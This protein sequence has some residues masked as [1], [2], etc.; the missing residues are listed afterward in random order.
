MENKASHSNLSAIQSAMKLGMWVSGA[1]FAVFGLLTMQYAWAIVQGVHPWLHNLFITLLDYPQVGEPGLTTFEQNF[2]QYR[3]VMASMSSHALLGGVVVLLGMLQFVPYLRRVKPRVHRTL[4]KVLA[5]CMTIICLSALHF[6]AVT[7]PSEILAGQSFYFI[8]L[9]LAGLALG[10]ISQ[11]VLAVKSGDYRSHM[12]WMGLAFCAFLTAPLLRFNYL[13]VGALDPQVL[14]R[15]VINS[16]P[17]VLT[18]AFV[19]WMLWL[20]WVGD[21]DLPR[22]AKGVNLLTLPAVWAK[23][24]AWASAG[25]LLA[26]GLLATLGAFEAHLEVGK[27][28]FLALMAAFV[29]SRVI[30]TVLSPQTWQAG[31]QGLAPMGNH[32]LL[33]L[34]AAVGT[35]L[36]AFTFNTRD[37]Y[38]HSLFHC[39]VQ[40]TLLELA[41][42][43]LAYATPALSTGRRIFT[44]VSAALPWFWAGVPGLMLGLMTLGFE[45]GVGAVASFALVPPLFFVLAILVATDAKLFV[46][47]QPKGSHFKGVQEA[48]L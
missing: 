30:Q 38:I 17:V 34:A 7:R 26:L 37:F 27:L 12:V 47:A 11:A 13:I 24:L 10:L 42:L 29:V 1:V 25:S 18:Q 40:F 48:H 31:M 44:L 20:T 43:G 41:V 14:N 21:K 23:G 19:L 5:L 28:A 2:A 33:T 4:G 6:L 36:L 45:W 46:K 32:A 9:A 8:L 39:L 35:V 16:V 22:R 3:E 15:L